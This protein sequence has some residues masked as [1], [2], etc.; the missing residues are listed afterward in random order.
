M[1]TKARVSPPF[2][3]IIFIL[4]IFSTEFF[5]LPCNGGAMH[6]ISNRSLFARIS[7]SSKILSCNDRVSRSQCLHS[8]NCKWCRSE[9]ID[10]MCFS[11]N[12]AWRLPQQVYLCD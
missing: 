3:L 9:F 1:A 8:L 11:S 4:A 5:I 12:E 2:F 6:N 10:D 7:N